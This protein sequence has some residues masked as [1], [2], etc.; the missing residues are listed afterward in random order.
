[1]YFNTDFY[2]LLPSEVNFEIFKSKF[3]FVFFQNKIFESKKKNH[4]CENTM[5][6]SALQRL[7]TANEPRAY[8]IIKV[9]LQIKEY[10][11][12]SNCFILP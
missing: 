6:K 10:D 3:N 11:L 9:D 8:Q 5:A 2:S 7:A 1:M 12:D 4:S